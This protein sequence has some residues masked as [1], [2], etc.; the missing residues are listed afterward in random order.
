MNLL[1]GLATLAALSADLQSTAQGLLDDARVE[2]GAGWICELEVEYPY[3]YNLLMAGLYQEPA[4]V[5]E[6]L[7]AFDADI[8]KLKKSPQ[9]LEY[10]RRIQERI[11]GSRA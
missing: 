5:L 6:A 8:R 1:K 3:A 9:A 7:A 11:R 2:R 10:V 4:D